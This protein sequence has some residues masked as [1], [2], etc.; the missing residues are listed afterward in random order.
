MLKASG[1]STMLPSTSTA[2]RLVKI[3]LVAFLVE[4]LLILSTMMTMVLPIMPTIAKRTIKTPRKIL[5]EVDIF[6]HVWHPFS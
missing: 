1:M 2:A 6:L 3:K 4:M 5:T